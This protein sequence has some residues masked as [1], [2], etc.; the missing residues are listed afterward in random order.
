MGSGGLS[1]IVYRYRVDTVVR[2]FYDAVKLAQD[3]LQEDR[4]D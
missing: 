1:E 3:V 4:D 2:H